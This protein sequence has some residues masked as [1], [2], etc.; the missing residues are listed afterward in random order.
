M[1]K[2]LYA[3]IIDLT[4]R[5]SKNPSH[6]ELLYMWGWPVSEM[7]DEEVETEYAAICKFE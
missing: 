4:K 1:C 5:N 2:S 3:E 7:T 6:R